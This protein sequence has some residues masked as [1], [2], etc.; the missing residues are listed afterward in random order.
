MMGAYVLFIVITVAAVILFAVA[1][2]KPILWLGGLGAWMAVQGMLAAYGF[3]TE[4][5][6]APDSP[7]G[8]LLIAPPMLAIVAMFMLLAGRRVADRFSLRALHLLHG[9]RVPVEIGLAMLFAQ[10]L[11]PEAMTFYGVN[12]DILAGITA[13]LLAAWMQWGKPPRAVLIG[14]NVVALGLVLNIATIGLLSAP[15]PLQRLNFGQPNL[16]V[17]RFPFNWLPAVVVPLVILAHLIALRQLLRRRA[18]R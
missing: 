15:G 1:S 11:V 10:G 6:T 9:L 18:D 3:Y 16:A 4:I 17:L 12:F 7:R 5:A 14:W 8:A 13:L 2:R